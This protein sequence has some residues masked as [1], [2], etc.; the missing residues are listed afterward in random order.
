[1]RGIYQPNWVNLPDVVLVDVFKYLADADRL[2][3]SQVC[4][5]WAQIFGSPCLWRTRSFEMGGYRAQI[6]G[7]KACQFA[8]NFGSYLR[9]LSITCSHP[10]YYTCKLFQKSIDQLFATL[11]EGET[12]LI[13]FEMCR[14]ELERYWKYDTPKEKLVSVFSKFLKTQRRMKCF[15]MS[16]AQLPAYGGCRVLD[17]VAYQS[18][19]SIQDLL[20]EDFF[21]SRLSVYQVKK[22]HKTMSKFTALK[23]V[24]LNY[25]CLS[26]EVL[27]IFAKSLPGKLTF[28]NIKVFRYDPHMHR[29][30]GLAWKQLVR[31]C[32]RL[33]VAVW[34]ESIGMHNEIIPILAKEAP[35][36]DIHIWSGYD[37]DHDWRLADTID[38]ITE[39]YATCLGL[40]Q[41][42]L[43]V[44]GLIYIYAFLFTLRVFYHVQLQ[45]YRF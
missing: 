19:S 36:K 1:M 13:E 4:K 14:L 25:N 31:A 41:H 21:H 18:G 35:I 27:D 24:A 10:S 39:S 34:I 42:S 26:D 16:S 2:N 33:R 38:H 28:L 5:S 40:A 8:E 17:A 37:D 22:F 45:S 43:S 3:A 15:D 23:Y 7:T 29:I 44:Y 30:S 20:I 6:N 12:Q 9:Y 11:K 32:P